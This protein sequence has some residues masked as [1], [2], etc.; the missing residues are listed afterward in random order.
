MPHVR[1]VMKH[2]LAATVVFATA[3]CFVSSGSSSQSSTSS[4]TGSVGTTCPPSPP[5]YATDV[6]PLL[7]S[8]CTSCHQ[9]SGSQSGKPLDTYSSVSSLASKVESKVSDCSMPP[10]SNPQPSAAERDVILAWIACG[11]P[12]N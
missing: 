3:S 10:S 12:N 5:S 8:Y 1:F 6:S 9:P 4:C 11:S 7:Y 2:W